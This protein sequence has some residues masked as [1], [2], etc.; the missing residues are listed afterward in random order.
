MLKLLKVSLIVAGSL[1]VTAAASVVT[2]ASPHTDPHGCWVGEV[3]SG[4]ACVAPTLSGAYQSPNS[5]SICTVTI[6]GH[7]PAI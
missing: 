2:A 1:A 5:P 4:G 7:C 6:K 3:Y